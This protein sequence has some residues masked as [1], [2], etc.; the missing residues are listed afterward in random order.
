MS[1]YSPEIHPLH[2]RHIARLLSGHWVLDTIRSSMKISCL[3]LHLDFAF[4]L[5]RSSL[6]ATDFFQN[7]TRAYTAYRK[8]SA[9]YSTIFG[10]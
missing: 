1:L 4:S 6:N 8:L 2:S 10:R 5:R 9:S 3:M 7:Q